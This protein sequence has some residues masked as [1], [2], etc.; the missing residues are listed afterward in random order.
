MQKLIAVIAGGDSHEEV[1]SLR[2]CQTIMKYLDREKYLPVLVLMKGTQW[3]AEWKGERCAIDKNDFSFLASDGKHLFHGAYVIIHGPPG[4]DGILPAWLDLMGIPHST[5]HAF[6]GAL[7]FNKFV[8]NQ[9]AK[10][11]G[12]TIA[13][14]VILSN[15]SELE[16]KLISDKIGFPCFV[17]P[18]DSGSSFGVTKVKE[19]AQLKSAVKH[20]FEHGSQVIIE[21]GVTGIEVSCGV[22]KLQDKIQVLPVTEIVPTTE[23]FD[24]AAKYEGKSEEI[25]PARISSAETEEV[26][27][28][29]A[30]LYEK[31]NLRGLA[32]IDFIIENRIPFLIEINTI[33]GMSE[34]SIIPQ[35]VKVAGW[36]LK[37][38]L[39]TLVDEMFEK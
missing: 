25:T 36:D 10:I 26:Q 33:P 18:N 11:Y 19:K 32:R 39:T 34:Q 24:F 2:S 3:H 4:E 20:A 5:N 17:K 15:E 7:T 13:P 8:C 27:R 38:L 23:F 12:A 30:M 14:S 35:Q 28:L 9:L 6:E 21:K 1:I 37:W 22:V 31:M 16:E 29:T